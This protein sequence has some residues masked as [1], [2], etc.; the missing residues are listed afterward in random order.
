MGAKNLPHFLSTELDALLVFELLGQMVI[1]ES[2]VFPSGH[3][4]DF[5]YGPLLHL[6]LAGLA[7]IAMDHSLGSLLF[8]PSFNSVALPLADPGELSRLLQPLTPLET[9]FV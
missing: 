5:F 2:L 1:V 6:A 7:S 9:L 4:H 3:S 8:D